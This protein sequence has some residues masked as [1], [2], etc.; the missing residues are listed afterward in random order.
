MNTK[1]KIVLGISVLVALFLVGFSGLGKL[2][3][4]EEVVAMFTKGGINDWRVIIGIGEV[5]SAILFAIPLTQRI[6]TWL[7][8][9]YFG[10]A[11]MLHM[12]MGESI[13]AP[14]AFL[15]IIWV[16][17]ILRKDIPIKM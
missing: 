17:S 16:L 10:G 7:L 3:G 15:L 8:S 1:D 11:I 14:V 12:T 6:G 5:V 4:N 2:T 9:S 13:M